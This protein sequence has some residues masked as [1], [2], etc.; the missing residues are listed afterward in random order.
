MFDRYWRAT[1][2]GN[3]SGLGLALVRAVA[4]H[5]G[6]HASARLNASGRGLEVSMTFGQLVDW[7]G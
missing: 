6:G 3:G 7:H 5:H 4:E 2:D 1:S